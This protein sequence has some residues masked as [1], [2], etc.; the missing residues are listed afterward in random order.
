MGTSLRP[1]CTLKGSGLQAMRYLTVQHSFPT[2]K[3]LCRG[4]S[5]MLSTFNAMLGWCS[6][7]KVFLVDNTMLP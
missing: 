4:E 7:A 3:L 6:S 1:P 2:V 5:A